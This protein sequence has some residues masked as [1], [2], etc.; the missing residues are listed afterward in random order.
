LDFVPTDSLSPNRFPVPLQ[1]L[2]YQSKATVP[3]SV[4]QLEYLLG[5][6]RTHNHALSISGLLL[7]GEEEIIQVIEGPVESVHTLYQ[8]IARDARHYDV[9][10]LADSPIHKRAFAEWSMGFG[11][12]E[13]TQREKLTG[14]VGTVLSG[15]GL[16]M[17]PGQWPELTAML[18][19]FASHQL[20]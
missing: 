13:T 7:Y 12:L 1:Q 4:E 3:F 6:W 20:S 11:A 9:I 15:H 16:P 10:T 14:Y 8:T 17:H 19:E 18:R 2:V 5:P